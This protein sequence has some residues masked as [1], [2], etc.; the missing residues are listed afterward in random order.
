MFACMM[1]FLTMFMFKRRATNESIWLAMLRGWSMD[2]FR[3]FLDFV[4]D[5]VAFPN[6]R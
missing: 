4:T 3:S 5:Q 2:R 6:G 1:R